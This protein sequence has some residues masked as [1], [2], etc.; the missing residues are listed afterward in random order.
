MVRVP[1]KIKLVTF[2]LEEERA[3]KTY[4]D[5]KN[6]ITFLSKLNHDYVLAWTYKF[7]FFMA[8]DIADETISESSIH[9]VSCSLSSQISFLLS[10]FTVYT[11]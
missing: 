3:E 11:T 9:L 7:T 8:V 4:T 5:N 10:N 6:N 1:C 2:L